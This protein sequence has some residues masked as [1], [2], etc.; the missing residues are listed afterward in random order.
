M[1]II[2]SYPTIAPKT[3]DLVLISDTSVEGN[4][5]KTATVESI[6][7]LVNKGY[8]SYVARVSQNSGDAPVATVIHNDTG[9]TVTW[10]RTG[11]GVYTAAT[12]IDYTNGF[13][14]VTGGNTT[15]SNP[16]QIIVTLINPASPLTLSNYKLSDGSLFDGFLAYIEI[17]TYS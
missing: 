8:N 14:Q 7:T 16:T 13:I 10:A 1:A 11:P 2:N 17:R 4:P 9:K 3:S 6:S 15:V 5:T 12:T